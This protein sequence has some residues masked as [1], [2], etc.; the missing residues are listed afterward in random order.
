MAVKDSVLMMQIYDFQDHHRSEV[1]TRHALQGGHVTSQEMR[2]IIVQD[3]G[4]IDEAWSSATLNC[5][6]NDGPKPKGMSERLC[7]KLAF[8][9]LWS[10]HVP[11][12]A[13]LL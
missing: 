6:E 11:V 7:S 9:V 3:H 12:N 13:F 4:A 1:A 5:I 2:T 8:G 10:T